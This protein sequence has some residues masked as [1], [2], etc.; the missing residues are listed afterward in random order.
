MRRGALGQ[1]PLGGGSGEC[2]GECQFRASARKVGEKLAEPK[3]Q[4]FRKVGLLW[5]MMHWVRRTLPLPPCREP[6][7][8]DTKKKLPS[9]KHERVGKTLRTYGT[10]IRDP[11]RLHSEKEGP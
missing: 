3:P 8:L 7:H 2:Q 9:S 6:K 11:G 4:S 10:E 1:L 5:V